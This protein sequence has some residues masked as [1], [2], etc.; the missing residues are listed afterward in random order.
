MEDALKDIN[1]TTMDLATK[2]EIKEARDYVLKRGSATLLLTGAEHGRY[3]SMKDQMQQNMAMG[4]N[5][6][7]KSIDETVN[8]LNTY[9]RMN[10]NNYANK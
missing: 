10:K 8:I 9:S 4:T 2:K 1:N 7:P 5:N 3:G 6:Y